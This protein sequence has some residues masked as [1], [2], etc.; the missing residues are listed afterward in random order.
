MAPEPTATPIPPT[1]TDVPAQ[2]TAAPEP[3]AEPIPAT[4]TTAPKP[5]GGTPGQY[6]VTYGHFAGGAQTDEFK[7]SVWVMRGDGSDATKIREPGFEPSVSANGSLV[8][9]YKPWSGLW[10]YN[11]QSKEDRQ[12]D[13]SPYAEFASFSPD[14][15]RVVYHEWVGNWWSAN[16]NL[17]II[18]ADG[19]GKT[20]LPQGNRAAWSPKGGLIAFDTCRDNRCGIW[21]VQPNGQGLREITSDSG[22]MPGWSPDGKRLAYSTSK[23]GD[24]EIWIVNLDGSGARQLTKNSGNDALPVFSPDGVYIYYLSDQDGT[25]WAIRRMRTDGSEVK[26]IRQMGV[27]ERWQFA[28]LWVNWW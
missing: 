7:Y 8:A 18:N 24:S 14:N 11:M 5:A 3:T 23:D 15:G 13:A 25:A 2:P 1:A 10:I 12:L 6:R 20:Q 9:Y 4:A 21:V 17:Y 19:T 22:G 27:A 28:R 16:V 26:T